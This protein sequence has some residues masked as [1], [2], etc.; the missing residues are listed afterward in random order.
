MKLYFA[1]LVLFS[2]LSSTSYAD[3]QSCSA[4]VQ[5]VRLLKREV[6]VLENRFYG[7]NELTSPEND[8]CKQVG[9]DFSKLEAHFSK[10]KKQCKAVCTP[11]ILKSLS[12]NSLDLS[13]Y[14]CE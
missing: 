2:G 9:F 12:D 7:C 3:S 5:E 4:K 1:T 8:I 11:T 10:V 14:S 13:T 6:G